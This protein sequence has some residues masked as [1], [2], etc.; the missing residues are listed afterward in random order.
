MSNDLYIID[1]YGLIYRSYY[2]FQGRAMNNAKGENIAAVLA[3]FR[4][5]FS[6][7]KTYNPK[8]LIIA[9]DSREKTFR[10]DIY[11]EYKATRQKAPDDLHSQT[12]IIEEILSAL[13]MPTCR[14]SGFEAD[15]VIGTFAKKRSDENLTTYIISSDK[16]LMQLVN[17]N[18]FLLRPGFKDGFKLYTEDT[19]FEDKKVKPSQIVDYLAI[20]GDVSDNIPGVRGLGEKA[21]EKLL[22]T[23]ENLEDIYANIDKVEPKSYAEKLIEQKDNA[24]LS[25]KLASLC[26]DVAIPNFTDDDLSTRNLNYGMAKQLFTN[27]G[28]NS[29]ASDCDK[30]G[31]SSSLDKPMPLSNNSMFNFNDSLETNHITP[32]KELQEN[33][34]A[35]IMPTELS[36]YDENKQNYKLITTMDD[37][38][39][40]LAKLEDAKIFAFDS[41]TTGLD[42]QKD[43]IVGFSFACLENE[44]YYLPVMGNLLDVMLTESDV[45]PLL[46]KLLTNPNHKVIGQNIKYDMKMLARWGI[47]FKPYFDTMIASQLIDSESLAN[48]D[49]LAERYLAY[50][51]IAFSDVVDKKQ[52]FNQISLDKA[53]I[54]ASED[55]DITLKLYHHLIKLLEEKNLSSLFFNLEMPLLS[56]L[57]K[58]ELEGIKLNT[59]K[60]LTLKDIWS[61]ELAILE[62]EIYALAG[63]EFNVASPKQLAEILFVDLNLKKTKKE[64]TA[65]DVLEELKKDHPIIKYI[66]N[67]RKLSK[68]IGTY[69]ESLVLLADKNSRIHT[70][71]A[72]LGAATGRLSSRNPNLQNIPIRDDNGRKIRECFEASDNHFLISADYSQIE[73]VVLANLSNDNVMLNTFKA[74]RDLHRETASFIFNKELDDI[75]HA[76]RAIAKTINFGVLYGMSAFRLSNE[77]EI[78]RAKAK[79]YIDNYF[80]TYHQVKLFM[81]KIIEV[82]LTKGYVETL[83]GRYRPLKG[84]YSANANERNG[85]ERAA[86]NTVVQGS[87]ADIVKQAMLNIDKLITDNN[88]KTKILLQ[89]HDEI[90][91]ESPED[92]LEIAKSILKKAMLSATNHLDIKKQIPLNVSIESGTHWGE[93]H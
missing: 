21:C 39:T 4:S 20:L 11:T 22:S 8:E 23:F 2:A 15:D 5:L 76:E 40:M 66:I 64:S 91:L 45:K 90:I 60:I 75:S 24:Y 19:V 74:G 86:I 81:D 88:L 35:F 80:K 53:C 82:G 29:L 71:F 12:A 47:T 87:A 83:F 30:M 33:P 92:E 58:M 37:F 6:I 16:D 54:Y 65:S 77:L 57:C 93:F 9:L 46:S 41:E 44:A 48:M 49:F 85:A 1:G 31:A 70:D 50:K 3:F 68:L 10:S 69:T 13:N 14:I 55:A 52:T 78:S 42:T 51:T 56:V 43:S 7:L 34:L 79:E 32:K 38:K 27:N 89:I 84:L 59:S 67:H 62:T 36:C 73:L 61:K 63:K 26:Y 72:Q 25:Y 28:L 17:H 18:T